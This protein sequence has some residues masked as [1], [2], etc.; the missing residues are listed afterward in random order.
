MPEVGDVA[1]ARPNPRAAELLPEVVGGP[2]DWRVSLAGLAGFTGA[3]AGDGEGDRWGRRVDEAMVGPTPEGSR[4][5]E[6]GKRDES[7][8]LSD[9]VVPAIREGRR[10]SRGRGGG[11]RK[12][13]AR[14]HVE[15]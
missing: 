3:G 1:C 6:R 8:L 2:S 15:E 4:R 7:L 14:E 9:W 11:Q 10:V 5:R 13:R 12:S